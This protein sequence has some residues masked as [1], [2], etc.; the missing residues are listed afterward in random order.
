[1]MN[2]LM[3]AAS[4]AKMTVNDFATSFSQF[5]PA[6]KL[7]GTNASNVGDAFSTFS[8]II[9]AF[10]GGA[11]GL[12]TAESDFTALAD[13]VSK[14]GDPITTMAGGMDKLRADIADGKMGLAMKAIADAA[15]TIAGTAGGMQEV[16]QAFGLTV[17][18]ANDLIDT[19]DKWKT[20]MDNTQ[21]IAGNIA[22]AEEGVGTINDRLST[23]ITFLT[24][25]AKLWATVS[26]A[27]QGGV[28]QQSTSGQSDLGGM[29]MGGV[30]T[31]MMS[32]NVASSLNDLPAAPSDIDTLVAKL[33]GAI[34]S[35]MQTASSTNN[36]S[37]TINQKNNISIPAG[38]VG[39][40]TT[41][42]YNSVFGSI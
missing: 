17:K 2:E 10:G 21:T 16:E 39:S 14:G 18:Q 34:I 5:I 28:A 3:T 7:G 4:G 42:L 27:M 11:N 31:P 12:P 23:Q 29:A 38:Q 37:T 9:E 6:L 1:M 36:S 15:T 24:Q 32:G 22:L 26:V 8:G 30:T 33:S 35:G 20:I 19:K 13:A 25:L 40:T 41:D